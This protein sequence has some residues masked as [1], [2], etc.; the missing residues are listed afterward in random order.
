MVVEL[1]VMIVIMVMIM[2]LL[3]LPLQLDFIHGG[4]DACFPVVTVTGDK[5]ILVD[6]HI[7][8]L[9]NVYIEET[10]RYTT[11]PHDFMFILK[12]I[13]QGGTIAKKAVGPRPGDGCPIRL[14]N[15]LNSSIT[16][17][18]AERAQHQDE[19]DRQN[20]PCSHFLPPNQ[21]FLLILLW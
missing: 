18:C 5:Y 10:A 21:N 8:I 9:C 19:A 2:I 3:S 6:R 20:N 1:I 16:A 13:N 11:I 7:S 15:H 12:W 4:P 17:L 14:D